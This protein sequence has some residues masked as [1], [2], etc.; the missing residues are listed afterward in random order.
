MPKDL[1]RAEGSYPRPLLSRGS[2][3]PLDVLCGFAFDD[4]DRGRDEHWERDP[5]RFHRQIQL[6]FAPES[7]ASGIGETGF[8]PVAW[9]R[10]PFA[11]SA[12]SQAGLGQQGDRVILHFGAVD[13]AADV[14]VDGHHTLSHMGGQVAFS[15]DITSALDPNGDEHIITVRAFDDPLDLSAPRGKQDWMNE[16]HHIW[17]QRT[18]GIWRTVW[19]EAVP[20][21]S[22]T[23]LCWT[24]ELSAAKVHAEVELSR[25][26]DAPVTVRAK[27]AFEGMSLA[28]IAVRVSGD[29]AFFDIPIDALRNNHSQLLWSPE[30]PRLVDAI[31]SLEESDSTQLDVVNSY[32]GLRSTSVDK[33]H[34][35]LNDRPYYV[36]SVLEQGYW[37]AS[38][39]TAPNDVALREEVELILSLGF[40][41]AR[42]HQKAEDPRFIYWCDR[43]GLLIWGE[44]AGAYEF[45]PRAVERLTHE[46]IAIIRQYR[47][48]P[49]IVT[50][51]PFNE[52]W[53]IPN[54]AHILAERA[55]S[56]ALTN[57][58]RALDPSRPV[59]SNDGWEHTDSDIWTV[60]DYDG[61]GEVLRQRYGSASSVMALIEGV[62]PTG[63]LIRTT[64]GVDRGQP[65]MLTEFGGVSYA[66]GTDYEDSWGYSS[67]SDVNEFR[68]RFTDIMRGV[69]DSPVLSGFCYTQ[70][71]DTR[72]ETNGLCDEN[73]I[74]K[75]PAA[76]IRATVRGVQ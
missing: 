60:H 29:Q 58:T 43:L 67:V 41:A 46:W 26:P 44:T 36:R 53:G 5:A 49:A 18:T 14:W 8:H 68:T 33:G 22:I 55:F 51:V 59:V 74:P 12:L 71:T 42:I 20:E 45:S 76:D 13:Y 21:L 17:Y 31:V 6:P 3:L 73:R 37:P 47:S 48:H 62:G 56:L 2:Y 50:W 63:H 38:N 24:P 30:S 72:Q 66:T 32:V 69:L 27:L 75:L 40:N 15:A 39:F 9:Y 7:A 52:S 16:P 65:V 10:I 28:E 70:L 25:R 34:F 64:Q 57:L 35:M 1:G 19:L 23:D 11:D 4:D 54:G 61:S